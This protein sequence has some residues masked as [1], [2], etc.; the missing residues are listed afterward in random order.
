MRRIKTTATSNGATPHIM[1]H[2]NKLH[3]S[4]EK[5]NKNGGSIRWKRELKP[6]RN[7]PKDKKHRH[8]YED[9]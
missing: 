3:T 4:Q 1:T 9:F 7:T 2:Y 6:L 5:R 8:H